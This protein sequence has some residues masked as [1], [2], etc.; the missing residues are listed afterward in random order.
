M[1]YIVYTI[2]GYTELP[3][4]T[5][6]D[7]CQIIDFVENT[8]LSK[9]EILEHYSKEFNLRRDKINAQ[10]YIYD[11]CLKALQHVVKYYL[12]GEQKD[13]DKAENRNKD[14][15]ASLKLLATWLQLPTKGESQ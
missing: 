12:N 3:I 2:D 1:N 9:D 13:C 7:N 4:G 11:D 10:P 5:E 14:V 6:T 15:H 8:N